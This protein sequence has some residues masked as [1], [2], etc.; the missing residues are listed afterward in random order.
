MSS[1]GR[2]ENEENEEAEEEDDVFKSVNDHLVFL[3]DA[4]QNMF[5][6][7]LRQEVSISDSR[8]DPQSDLS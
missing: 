2:D 8:K 6:K 5:Q 3:I 7:N 4:R 1:W